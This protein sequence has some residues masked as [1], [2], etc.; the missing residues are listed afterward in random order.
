MSMF[1]CLVFC[2]WHKVY[3]RTL[4]GLSAV[5]AVFLSI[6]ASYGLMFI[7]GIPFTSITQ[8][9][10]FI[11]FGIGLDDAFIIMGSF[12]R[13]DSKKGHVDRISDTIDDVGV[14]I[15]L[16]TITSSLAFGIASCISSIPAVYWLCLYA[17]PAVIVVYFY[18]ITFF[19]A[20]I[21][22]DEQRIQERRRDVCTWISVGR[23]DD[24][25]N[26]VI[27]DATE[28]K[29]P[30]GAKED[31]NDEVLQNDIE[32]KGH[33]GDA[34]DRF[35]VRYA[36][37]LLRPWV[38]LFVVIAFAVLGALCA[39][40]ASKLRQEF[41]ITD[42]L[43]GD[44]YLVEF[45]E[46]RDDYSSTNQIDTGLY[47]RN[48]NQ[49][50]PSILQQMKEYVNDLV[51]MEAISA[52]PDFFWPDDLKRFVNF[53]Q[54]QNLSFNEQME[55]FLGVDLINK[56]YGDDIVLDSSGSISASRS[57]LSMDK[58]DLEDVNSQIDVFEELRRVSKGQPINGGKSERAFFTYSWRD[59][60]W[61][62]Y[63]SSV[64]QLI[65][66]AITGVIC[67]T[68]I[69]FLMIPHW[70]AAPIVLPMMCILYV[71]LLGVMQWGGVTINA[72]SWVTL[73][74]SIG[75]LVDFIMHVLLRYYESPG[76]RREKTIEMLRTMGSS[77]LLGGI[78][79]FLGTVPLAFSTS[80]IFGTVFV[81]FLGMVTLGIA[82]GLI[83][84]PV[85]LSTIGTEE[86][87]TTQVIKE[88]P[89]ESSAG[90]GS[91]VEEIRERNPDCS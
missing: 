64:H 89:S 36:E 32:E 72:V 85:I 38:K 6:A 58:V 23:E 73:A 51:A 62:F 11:I 46:R 71:D 61:E 30:V 5:V 17:F 9:L 69:T 59:P 82:H 37:F 79:T 8:L 78:S 16:T 34:V 81:A 52:G 1:T 47:F 42:V 67:V 68:A 41:E 53:T 87:V 13:T 2:K 3:S 55:M 74:M 91:S 39:V 33:A 66:S 76:N 20:C 90:A 56:V 21:V 12:S 70:T 75:L 77:I 83:L 10:P 29:A 45:L 54:K 49:S 65:I 80:E 40:S 4:L 86:Q 50:D 48:V 60:Q 18:Q 43:P 22:L 14:S 63:A 57:F 27:Q 26:E 15:T 28:D 31:S 19:V 88:P 44:S 35:M 24:S 25:N 7:F 84:L